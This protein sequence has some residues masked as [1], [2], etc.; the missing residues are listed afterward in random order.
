MKNLIIV[1]HGKSDWNHDER[2][3]IDRP[4]KNRGVRD[5]YKMAQRL[6]KKNLKPDLVISSPADRALHTAIIFTRAMTVPLSR[7]KVSE[8]VY[9]A[10]EDEIFKLVSDTP[11][12]LNNLMLFGH[13]PTFTNFANGFLKSP[14][15]NI[16]TAGLVHLSFKADSWGDIRKENLKS[17]FFD[18]PKK[19]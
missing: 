8:M 9:H 4:L 3:D 19:S 6:T 16:P 11:D 1:R 13:N 2:Q 15:E 7:L 14:I 17:S 10:F 12:E 18:Y 5:A